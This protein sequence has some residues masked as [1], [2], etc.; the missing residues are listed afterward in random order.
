MNGRRAIVTY[1]KVGSRRGEPKNHKS[2]MKYVN[3]VNYR[4]RRIPARGIDPLK[5][6]LNVVGLILEYI[7]ARK[8]GNSSHARFFLSTNRENR[9]S[10]F[11][12]SKHQP[13][14]RTTMLLIVKE[15]CSSL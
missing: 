6:K 5:G 10:V 12:Y 15:V 3:Y 4:A 14:G 9:N 8:E 11:Q 1:P 13:I 2:G 7:E